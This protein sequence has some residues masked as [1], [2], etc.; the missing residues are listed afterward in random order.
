MKMRRLM[1]SV[2]HR[3]LTPSMIASVGMALKLTMSATATART[4]L[5][6]GFL[7]GSLEMAGEWVFSGARSR[8][9]AESPRGEEP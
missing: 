5:S 4:L 1:V 9:S 7:A 2:V 3:D 8:R 6:G